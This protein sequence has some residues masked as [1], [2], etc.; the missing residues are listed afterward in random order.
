MRVAVHDAGRRLYATGDGA[1]AHY[2]VET[3]RERLSKP[4]RFAVPVRGQPC[5]HIRIGDLASSTLIP[6]GVPE[7]DSDPIT[8]HGFDNINQSVSVRDFFGGLLTFQL[9]NVR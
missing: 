4:S 7:D 1:I 8:L 2:E 3:A 5:D 6:D 9:S